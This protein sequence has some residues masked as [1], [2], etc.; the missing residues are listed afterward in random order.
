MS[1][2]RRPTPTAAATT[3]APAPPAAAA[4]PAPA[5]A[6][7]ALRFA[8]LERVSTETQEQRGESLATQRKYNDRD[9]ARLGGTVVAHYGG[10]E[11]ATPGWEKAEV[12][13]L[14]ADAAQGKFDAVMVAYANRWS[15]DNAK[16]KAGLEVFRQ[17]GVRFF[18]GSVEKNL[19]EP[20]VKLELGLQAEI[21]EF[22]AGQQAKMSIE[23]RIERARRGVPTSGALPFGR[24][25]D[26]A[27][28][29]W[30]IDPAKHKMMEDAARRYLA[31][32]PL[33]RI[34]RDCAMNHASLCK[35]LRERCGDTWAITFDSDV[36]NIHETVT[37]TIPRLLDDQTIQAVRRRLVAN[38]T[39][40]HKP[41]RPVHDHLLSGYIFCAACGYAMFGQVN[42]CGRRYYRHAKAPRARACPHDPRPWVP[43]DAIE[44][45]VVR[46]LF[47]LLG[48]TAAID[49]AIKNAIPDCAELLQRK[50]DLE[51]K[52]AK[53][54]RGRAGVLE[55]VVREAI[56]QAQAEAK[57]NDLKQREADVRSD[58]GD[59]K[60]TLADV[61]DSG[62]LQLYV[63]DIQ[64][65]LGRAI[66]IV[67]DDGNTYAGG[68]DVQSYLMMTQQDRRDLLA[69]VFGVP[70]PGGKPSGVY[71]T[72]L[73]GPLHGPKRFSYEVRGRLGKLPPKR[74]PGTT[75]SNA[76]AAVS[77]GH[78]PP[79]HSG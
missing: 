75:A 18:V 15:R 5:P 19:F 22:V 59:I 67:D 74:L 69:S 17:H 55:L 36:L 31:G 27:T 79:D 78:G 65:A 71:I 45:A 62:A 21:G 66:M 54:E 20:Q 28:G 29:Q 39:Y 53:V 14:L 8:S 34:A 61:P 37:L 50:L 56:T 57:L 26:A 30:A 68:N 9:V 16:S 40:L 44:Q 49:R 77:S 10:Q 73:G 25:Y 12:D 63:Q 6:P 46:D 35:L 47:D 11:H 70:Q 48:N 23:N 2:R 64:D 51:A 43:A 7:A 1:K 58:L 13:R 33:P 52:L 38:R 4:A 32:E 41:P 76:V 24:T 3:P 60:A 72:P 42:T